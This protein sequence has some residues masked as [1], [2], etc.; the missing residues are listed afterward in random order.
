[1]KIFSIKLK[2][3]LTIVPTE[4]YGKTRTVIIPLNPRTMLDLVDY[5]LGEKYKFKI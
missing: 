3:M 2:M 4:K 1:M 5:T